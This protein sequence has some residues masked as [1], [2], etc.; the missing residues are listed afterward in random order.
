MLKTTTKIAFAAALIALPGAAQARTA[1]A[2]G[3]ASLTVVEKCSFNGSNL[4]FGARISQEIRQKQVRLG[5]KL[6]GSGAQQVEWGS[7][8]CGADTLYSLSIQRLDPLDSSS[9]PIQIRWRD[10]KETKFVALDV[11][12]KSIGDAPAAVSSSAQ[13]TGDTRANLIPTTGVSTG[14][15]QKI[16]AQLA[17]NYDSITGPGKGGFPTGKAVKEM[18]YAVHF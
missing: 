17:Y 5:G 13:P 16:T 3:T 1:T 15:L 10:A 9:E 4:D 14:K 18:V 6:R 12:I 11:L 8:K 2:T 7:V